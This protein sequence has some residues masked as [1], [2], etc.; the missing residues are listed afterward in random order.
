MTDA[1][2]NATT[3]GENSLWVEIREMVLTMQL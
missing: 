3:V 1:V 2:E